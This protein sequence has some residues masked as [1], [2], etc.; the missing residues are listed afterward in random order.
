MPAIAVTCP[1]TSPRRSPEFTGT[2]GFEH[3]NGLSLPLQR[4]PAFVIRTVIERLAA[5]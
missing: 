4:D 2:V 1:G 5:V 3:H